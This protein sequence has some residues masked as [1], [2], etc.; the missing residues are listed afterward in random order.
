[1]FLRYD[2]ANQI[3]GSTLFYEPE[4]ARVILTTSNEIIEMRTDQLTAYVNYEPV[5]LDIPIHME[6]DIP[7][8][9]VDYLGQ[10]YE[11]T[12]ERYENGVYDINNSSRSYLIVKALK[13]TYIRE[14]A[15]FRSPRITSVS[16]EELVSVYEEVSGWYKVRNSLGFLGYV[17]KDHFVLEKIVEA[18]P[19]KEEPF[20]PPWQ[21]IGDKINL[22]WDY[23]SRP[24]T[25][26]SAYETIPGLNVISPTWFHLL[27]GE[28]EIKSDASLEYVEW[29]HSEGLQVW[30]L[31][32]N[33][34][35][36]DFTRGV[37][38]DFDK[39]RKVISYMLMQAK[40]LGIDGINIDFENVYYEDKD[41]LTQFVREFAIMLH[42]QDLTVSM[43]V[44]VLSTNPDWSMVF[45]RPNLSKAVD[46]M[47]VMTYDEHWASSPK[48]GSV[49]SIPWVRSSLD[50]IIE[51][52]PPEKIL[53]G[54]PLYTRLWEEIPQD[55][56][57]VK[58]SSKAY[59]MNGI[60]NIL[61]EQETVY[62]F[63]NEAGQNYAEYTENGNIYK[64][65]L[66]DEVSLRERVRIMKE[67]SLAGI[68]TWRKGFEDDRV[69][70][71]L[72]EEI[73]KKP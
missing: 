39:R 41:Y 46:Y 29:A 27:N 70:S 8:V 43:D 72:T 17:D 64:V 48:A 44:T 13:D 15:D 40:L 63:D 56:G 53:M 28:G 58:V 18:V 47:A 57:S 19:V 16:E 67:Y 68:A 65:W 20:S 26:M 25:D 69:W 71:I 73:S 24:K 36:P 30:A 51:Q 2:T 9:S 11:F 10:I 55:D 49:G 33:G 7:Y 66:E 32:D 62:S 3:L 60:R 54:I 4:T 22:T 59:S 50:S 21:P 12:S 5:D 31:F 61:S 38:R 6:E 23:M 14:L 37:L 1:L 42:E 35:D 34:F 52:I 45:D